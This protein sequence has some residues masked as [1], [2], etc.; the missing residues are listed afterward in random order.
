MNLKNLQNECN[1]N[2]AISRQ[3][4][5]V[6]NCETERLSKD[7]RNNFSSF[8]VVNCGILNIG[9]FAEEKLHYYPDTGCYINV[10]HNCIVISNGRDHKFINISNDMIK[11]KIF[12]GITCGLTTVDGV[13]LPDISTVRQGDIET[14]ELRIREYVADYVSKEKRSTLVATSSSTKD[15]KTKKKSV[16]CS[17]IEDYTIQDKS[18]ELYRN[19]TENQ[20]KNVL[21]SVDEEL[22]RNNL[23]EFIKSVPDYSNLFHY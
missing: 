13:K 14:I 18:S 15:N 10:S 7:S 12:K 2:A 9:K 6:G 16:I 11:K 20:I 17:N 8:I 4:K 3:N 19:S 1:K 21:K 5:I 23:V 22:K